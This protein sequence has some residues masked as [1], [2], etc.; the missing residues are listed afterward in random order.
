MSFI[1]Y[2]KEQE[3]NLNS[4]AIIKDVLDYVGVG[5]ENVRQTETKENNI[6]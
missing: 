5:L 4:G 2:L 3:H 6:S 1:K